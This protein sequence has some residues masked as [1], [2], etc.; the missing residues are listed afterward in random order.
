LNKFINEVWVL[1]HGAIVPEAL[2]DQSWWAWPGPE[3]SPDTE[4]RATLASCAPE[5]AKMLLDREWNYYDA[6]AEID[7]CSDCKVYIHMEHLSD[8][9]WLL[10]MKKAKLI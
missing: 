9:P 8:C 2:E 5:M 7:A 3:N 6:Q 4:E 10:L 1:E